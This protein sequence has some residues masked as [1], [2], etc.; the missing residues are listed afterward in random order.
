MAY[1]KK[2]ACE[3]Q[4]EEERKQSSSAA[5][6]EVVVG[7][8]KAEEWEVLG[9]CAALMDGSLV[10]AGYVTSRKM[11]SIGP[12]E[13]C[14]VRRGTFSRLLDRFMQ[15]GAAMTQYK[16]PRCL[17]SADALAL[18]RSSAVASFFSSAA[19]S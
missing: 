4:E 19:L 5:G 15:S 10:E 6:D 13:L 8:P 3:E 18:L 2:R 12:L 11:G 14:V 1:K 17:V 16:T 7:G 9:E